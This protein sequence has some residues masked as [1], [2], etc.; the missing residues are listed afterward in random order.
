MNSRKS[1]TAKKALK[2]SPSKKPLSYSENKAIKDIDL[3]IK[4]LE[5][6][7]QK[8]QEG[9]INTQNNKSKSTQDIARER[10]IISEIKMKY[11][12]NLKNSKYYI[13]ANN[14]I[15][16]SLKGKPQK[17]KYSA[18]NSTVVLLEGFSTKLAAQQR[19]K[20]FKAAYDNLK[21]KHDLKVLE[22][23]TSSIIEQY[24]SGKNK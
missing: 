4:K 7:K 23:K 1:I 9:S 13:V 3:E 10:R 22:I 21:I 6:K 16:Q 5:E 8:I 17:L 20:H 24:L 19:K 2:A 18:G 12:I 15:I 14:S 11:G